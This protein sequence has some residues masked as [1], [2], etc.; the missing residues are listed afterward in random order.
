MNDDDSLLE[1]ELSLLIPRP[2]TAELKA[3]LSAR[4]SVQS[5]RPRAMSRTAVGIAV[6]LALLVLAMVGLPRRPAGPNGEIARHASSSSAVSALDD[7]APSVWNYRRAVI[8]P[9]VELDELLDRHRRA[10]SRPAGAASES[11]SVS[12]LHQ[13]SRMG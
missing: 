4:L 1:S 12:S 13:Q 7:S 5:A 8:E 9:A 10:S 3:K 11:F 2:P 6:A